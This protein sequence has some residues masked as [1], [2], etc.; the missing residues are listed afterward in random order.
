MRLGSVESNVIRFASNFDIDSFA[1]KLVEAETGVTSGAAFT[2]EKQR[3]TL[4]AT[5]QGTGSFSTSDVVV[6]ELDGDGHDVIGGGAGDDLPI[7]TGGYAVARYRG[8]FSRD[9]R[10]GQKSLPFDLDLIWDERAPQ[11]HRNCF[12]IVFGLDRCRSSYKMKFVFVRSTPHPPTLNGL[13]MDP[14]SALDFPKG[15]VAFVGVV[16]CDEA[17]VDEFQVELHDRPVLYGAWRPR[18]AEN[19]NDFDIEIINFGY[20][21][22]TNVGNIDPSARVRFSP[23]EISTIEGLV[24]DLFAH[25]DLR[26]QFS[27]FSVK[28]AHFLG[29]VRFLPGWVL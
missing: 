3:L 22:K 25:Q 8:S 24:R 13:A 23:E 18:F 11:K 29:A 27:P 6:R 1:S 12:A 15:K 26:E 10:A 19:G 4:F 21:N 9:R 14:F 2:T 16:R 28:I 20:T 5:K 7:G 17:G